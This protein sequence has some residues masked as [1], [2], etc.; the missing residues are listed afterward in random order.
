MTGRKYVAV[1]ETC[2]VS[3][4]TLVGLC[5]RLTDKGL[6]ISGVQYPI[7]DYQTDKSLGYIE[8]DVKRDYWIK[9]VPAHFVDETKQDIQY[10]HGLIPK[11]GRT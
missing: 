11:G 7:Y 8:Y 6:A 9:T 4:V 2:I 1:A 10:T 3:S 5:Q